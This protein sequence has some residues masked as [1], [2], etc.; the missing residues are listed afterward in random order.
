MHSN[1]DITFQMNTSN[2][3]CEQIMKT[4]SDDS[5]AAN[6]D[7]GSNLEKAVMDMLKRFLD[8]LPEL[9]KRA[10]ASKQVKERGNDGLMSI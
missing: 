3:Y 6:D 1:A 8:L 9:L 7:D 4:S 10:D 5:G 2:R